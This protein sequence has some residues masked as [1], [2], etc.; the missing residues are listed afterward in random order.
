MEAFHRAVI[1]A[2]CVVV[3]GVVLLLHTETLNA[4]RRRNL[5]TG[6][7]SEEVPTRAGGSTIG[8]LNAQGIAIRRQDL[9]LG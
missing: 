2:I 1:P 8:R 7:G 6:R 5:R 3:D 4:F 9:G